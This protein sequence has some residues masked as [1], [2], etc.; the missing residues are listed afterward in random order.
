VHAWAVV[1]DDPSGDAPDAQALLVS[2]RRDG[3]AH[4]TFVHVLEPFTRQG[5]EGDLVRVAVADLR[6]GG[7]AG[8]SAEPVALGHLELDEA[9]AS[10][11]FTRIERQLMAAPLQSKPLLAALLPESITADVR[12]YAQVAEIIVDAY[13]NDPGRELHAEVRTAIGAESF[14]RTAADGAYGPSRPGFIRLVRR[15]GKAVAAIVGCEAA[16]GVGFVLQ[17]VVRPEAR[18]QGLGTQLILELAQCFRDAGL[19]RMALGV[20]NDNPAR[21]LY[22]RLGFRKILP[23]NAYVWWQ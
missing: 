2:A 19:D 16:P 5:L 22:V 21:R 1:D 6:A 18:G 23:V 10:L 8:I 7:V 12:D 20:T 11:G 3:M 4:I 15:M 9:F 17:V 13:R 14:V